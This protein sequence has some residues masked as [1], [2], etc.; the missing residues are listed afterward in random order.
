MILTAFTV[1][2]SSVPK[3]EHIEA[4][5]PLDLSR[6][7]GQWYE[8]FRLPNR[9]ERG[10][11]NITANY[12]LQSD[13]TV[14][15]VNRGFKVASGQWSEATGKGRVKVPNSGELAVSFFGPFYGDYRV[16][17]LDKNYQLALVTSS[18]MDY[19]WLLSRVPKVDPVV[20][21]E[22]KLWAKKQGF[23]T[24]QLIFVD[25]TEVRP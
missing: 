25:H 15:V 19:L 11:E 21:N 13:G 3:S 4:V 20:V 2:C 8:I 1:G 24:D 6:Y 17:R 10:L 16:I 23:A 14:K 7:M 12:S 18:R 5:E 9:F 22:W